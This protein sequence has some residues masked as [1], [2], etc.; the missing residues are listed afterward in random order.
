M[1]RNAAG[2]KGKTAGAKAKGGKGNGAYKVYTRPELYE[3]ERPLATWLV[4]IAIVMSMVGIGMVFRQPLHDVVFSV[5][6]KG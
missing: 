1:G 4:R 2:R 5:L 3:D 6:G